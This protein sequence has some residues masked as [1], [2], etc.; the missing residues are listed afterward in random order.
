MVHNL[1]ILE[2]RVI[3]ADEVADH[4]KFAF[5]RHRV[6]EDVYVYGTEGCMQAGEYKK[7]LL[8]HREPRDVDDGGA[9]QRTRVYFINRPQQSK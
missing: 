8:F 3:D 7:H 5:V 9:E 6:D 2:E 4:L 1:G